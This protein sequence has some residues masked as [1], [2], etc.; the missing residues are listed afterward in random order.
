MPIWETKKGAVSQGHALDPVYVDRIGSNFHG[1]Y[2]QPI[3]QR[4][5]NDQQAEISQIFQPAAHNATLSEIFASAQVLFPELHAL[6]VEGGHCKRPPQIKYFPAPSV[7]RFP[8]PAPL[9]SR[10]SQSRLTFRVPSPSGPLLPTLGSVKVVILK[11]AWNI[12]RQPS[13]LN[14]IIRALPSIQELHCTYH[15]PKTDAYTT[16]SVALRASTFPP[17]IRHLN[18]CLEGL[19]AKNASSLAKWRKVYPTHHICRDIGTTAPQLE[20]L[21]YTGRLCGA[22]FSTAIKAAEQIRHGSTRLKRIDLI[23]QNVCRDVN[24]NNDGTGIHNLAF[25]QAFEILVIQA[26]RALAAYAEVKYMR[27]RFID[28]DSPDP[29]INPSFHLEGNK[30]WG[31]WSPEILGLLDTARPEVQFEGARLEDAYREVDL[32]TGRKSHSMEYY[33]AIAQSLGRGLI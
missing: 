30:A 18:I 25:I 12:V 27:I 14:T 28:L 10:P 31:F 22:L 17:T 19:Y 8:P 29:L 21:T 5:L 20:S 33:T 7:N 3:T 4:V 6:T 16:M 2:G 1:A 24:A 13:E 9:D 15:A 32:G 11:G 26:V 23:V